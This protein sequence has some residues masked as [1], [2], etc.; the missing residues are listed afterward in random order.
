MGFVENQFRHGEFMDCRLASR[1]RYAHNTAVLMEL[2]VVLIP[3]GS[4]RELE[5]EE[6]ANEEGRPIG[7]S[8]ANKMWT[9]FLHEKPSQE[10]SQDRSSPSDQSC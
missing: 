1:S 9:C 5:I 2:G 8:I 4:P 10:S 6:D 3:D 7:S